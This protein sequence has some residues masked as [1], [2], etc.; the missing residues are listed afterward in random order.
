[1][2]HRGFRL[3]NAGPL[4]L[5]L[6]VSVTALWADVPSLTSISPDAAKAGGPA[7]TLV[8]TGED[9][10]STSKI[11]WAAETL[12]D[13]TFVSSTQ[14]SARIPSS[15]ISNTGN[16]DVRVTTPGDDGGTSASRTFTVTSATVPVITSILPP[17]VTAGHQAIDLTLLGTGFNSTSVVQWNGSSRD[18]TFFSQGTLEARITTSDLDDAGTANVTVVNTTPLAA[19]SNTIVFRIETSGSPPVLTRLNPSFAI[20]GGEAFTL[21]V[22]G[23]DFTRTSVIR[24]DGSDRETTFVNSTTLTATISESDLEDAG[25]VDVTVEETAPG[26]AISNAL[27][28]TIDEFSTLYFPQIAVGGGYTTVLTLVN[29]ASAAAEGN[30]VLT[31]Q[32]GTPL[33]VHIAHSGGTTTTS[34]LPVTIPAGC[35]RIF[36]LTAANAGAPVTSGSARVQSDQTT[37]NG[38]STFKLT[39]N[40]V[41]DTFAGVLASTPVEAATIPV[42]NSQVEQRYTG[43]SIFNPGSQNINVHIVTLSDDGDVLD[44]IAPPELNP[45]RPHRQVTKFLHE[46]LPSRSSLAGSVVLHTQH[47]DRFVPVALV[48]EKGIHSAVPAVPGKPDVVPGF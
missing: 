25:D 24:W 36:T 28:F 8:V 26:G 14:L 37:L 17:S 16:V 30:I 13:T 11:Q 5:C 47:G 9:F 44:S 29:I 41:L 38:V 12:T 46:Y 48:L 4:S 45:L 7:F 27:V 35:T 42:D 34:S 20:R 3:R 43:F 40:G 39:V 19:R 18:T 21:T 10:E 23:S 22:T 15:F 32:A 2:K 6:L 1:M 31:S 33:S